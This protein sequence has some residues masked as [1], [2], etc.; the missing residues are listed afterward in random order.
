MGLIQSNHFNANKLAFALKTVFA[1][2]IGSITKSYSYPGPR[3][4]FA[5]QDIL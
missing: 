3:H 1:F 2:S 4:D 5:R